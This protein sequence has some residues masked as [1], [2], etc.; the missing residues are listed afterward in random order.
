MVESS[1]SSNEIDNKTQVGK[2]MMNLKCAAEQISW[3]LQL[4]AKHM[5]NI[6]FT[7]SSVLTMTPAPQ[8]R[9]I[10]Y[11]WKHNLQI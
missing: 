6:V 8:S 1:V 9:F 7:I 10:S 5:L 3:D 11:G 4:H 2:G